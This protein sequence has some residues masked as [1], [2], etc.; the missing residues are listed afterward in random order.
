MGRT[1]HRFV[2]LCVCQYTVSLWCVGRTVGRPKRASA[3]QEGKGGL[4]HLSPARAFAFWGLFVVDI[5][6]E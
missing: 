1:D 3:P 6:L 4:S 2:L 5:L